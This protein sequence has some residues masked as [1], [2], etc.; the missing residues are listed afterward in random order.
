M[1]S[2]GDAGC[3][4]SKVEMEMMKLM[5]TRINVG[6]ADKKRRILSSLITVTATAVKVIA[7]RIPVEHASLRY[8]NWIR[9]SASLS[10]ADF[11]ELG[12]RQ[13]PSA[14][15]R[16]IL[17]NCCHHSH[18]RPPLLPPVA[19][20]GFQQ[21][22]RGFIKFNVACRGQRKK[23]QRGN[24]QGRRNKSRDTK[25]VVCWD[26]KQVGHFRNQCSGA[27]KDKEVNNVAYGYHSDDILFCSVECATNSW[28]MDFSASF[29]AT[30]CT[31]TMRI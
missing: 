1:S 27:R 25:D 30:H 7:A 12:F 6:G 24:N 10:A 5:R 9:V 4:Q 16:P 2:Q 26:C 31:E 18:L 17:A 22:F 3:S 15:D 21:K 29:H 8:R 19:G 23:K 28:V 14:T 20:L 13:V 11:A